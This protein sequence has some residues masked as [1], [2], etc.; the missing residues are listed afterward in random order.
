MN[1]MLETQILPGG[2]SIGVVRGRPLPAIVIPPERKRTKERDAALIYSRNR[3]LAWSKWAKEH[4]EQIGYPTVSLLYK[5][6]QMTKVGIVRGTAYPRAVSGK[7]GKQHIEY[8]INA[9]GHATRSLRPPTIGDVPI[10]F[11]EVDE[12]VA[13]VP[14]KPREVGIAHYFTY[15]PIE[16]RVKVTPYKRARYMQLL[17]T[18]EY[19]VFV[20]LQVAAD[21][22]DN[23]DCV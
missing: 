6:M 10:E 22:A 15:G 3:L 7:D 18:F 2:I 9:D 5:A 8:P 1:A 13:G 11:V 21:R 16:D 14:S 23:F 17:E 20:G 12:A 19:T 4:R